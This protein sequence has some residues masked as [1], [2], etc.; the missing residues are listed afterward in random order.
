M[1]VLLIEDDTEIVEFISIAFNVGWPDVELLTTHQ[2]RRGI[3]LTETKSPDL[4]ILDLGLPDIS[5][6]EAL[7]QIRGFSDVPVIIET[8]RNSEADIV[9]G[10]DMGADEYIQKPFG[11]LELLAKMKVVLRRRC[12][13]DVSDTVTF[14]PLRLNPSTGRLFVENQLIPVTRTEALIMRCLMDNHSRVASYADLSEAIWGDSYLKDTNTLRVYIHR[15][16]QKIRID[17]RY[18]G[19]IASDPGIGYFLKVPVMAGTH[20]INGLTVSHELGGA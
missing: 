15:L 20:R 14:G 18:A 16:R 4:V 11:Q 3:E 7:K 5:G 12:V 2:G 1:K 19:V 13:T 6:F 8:V 9:K 10:L 17:A